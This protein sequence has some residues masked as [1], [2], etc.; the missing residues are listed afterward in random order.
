MPLKSNTFKDLAVNMKI[1]CEIEGRH[2]SVNL[3]PYSLNRHKCIFTQPEP[4]LSINQHNSIKTIN[5]SIF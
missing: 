2:E 5:P 3:I 1:V 4:K